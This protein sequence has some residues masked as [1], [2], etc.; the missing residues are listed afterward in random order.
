MSFHL[1]VG[2]FSKILLA[3]EKKALEENSFATG[4]N[5]YDLLAKKWFRA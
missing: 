3:L 4:E 5:T 2:K 1:F